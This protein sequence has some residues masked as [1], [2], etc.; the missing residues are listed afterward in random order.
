[1]TLRQARGRPRRFG[2]RGGP[3]HWWPANE[4][5]PPPDRGRAWRRGRG[6]FLRRAGCLL[7]LV[8]A[9]TAIG[10]TTVVRLFVD[11]AAGGS[12]PG[13]SG[14]LGPLAAL[15]VLAA[16]FV[17]VMRRVGVPAG[18]LIGAANRVADGDYSVRVVERGPPFL[19]S[20]TR[21]FN[22]MI[23]RLQKQDTVRRQLM[24]DIAHELRTPLSV[25]QGRLEGL[26]DGVYPRDDQRL[27]LVLEEMRV[28]ARLIEDMRTVANSESGTLTLEREP[29]DVAVLV[30]DT[31]QSLM[32]H[33]DARGVRLVTSCSTDLPL[34]DLDPLRV[35]EVLT[36]VIVNAIRHTPVG[37]TV[38]IEATADAHRLRLRVTDTG[39]GIAPDDLP[40]IFD[41]F[42]KASDS[43]GS[44]LGLAI[45]RALITAH[46]GE[47]RADSTLG[48][49]T[50]ITATLP[51]V[52]NTD[53][54]S[55]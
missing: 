12:L 47:I 51:L 5:W 23:A 21:A 37:G 11:R 13:V 10:T 53:N 4:A 31:V 27:R 46:D 7:I 15:I 52:V 6:R 14:V 28:L 18:D 38:A 35:R 48:Q 44:G 32:A 49:G 2:H 43:P 33:A 25:I 42:Y 54:R 40:R 26:L 41:R 19:R 50:T 36:N 55:I 29:T 39:S 22:L 3:P 45:A 30:T 1:M 8:L 9:L 24:A 34:V 20:F 16:A 17:A